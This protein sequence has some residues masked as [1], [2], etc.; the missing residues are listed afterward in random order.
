MTT[1][2]VEALLPKQR[3]TRAHGVSPFPYQAAFLLDNPSRPL[4]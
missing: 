4:A 1:T 3:E 2:W